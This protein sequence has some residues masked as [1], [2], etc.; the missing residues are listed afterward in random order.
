MR[1]S[2]LNFAGLTGPGMR[3]FTD[4]TIPELSNRCEGEARLSL[5]SAQRLG[6]SLMWEITEDRGWY[7][8][9]VETKQAADP[10]ISQ[11]SSQ[12]SR[13]IRDE[14]RQAEKSSSNR[15]NTLG[16]EP[17]CSASRGCWRSSARRG[18]RCGGGGAVAGVGGVGRRADCRRRVVRLGGHRRDSRAKPRKRGH[19]GAAEDRRNRE[20]RHSRVERR[21]PWEDL[22]RCLPNLDLTPASTTFSATSRHPKRV[23]RHGRSLVGKLDVKE[24]AKDKAAE[25]KERVVE[26]ADGGARRDGAEGQ[27]AVDSGARDRRTHGRSRRVAATPL[28]WPHPD[29]SPALD[30]GDASYCRPCLSAPHCSGADHRSVVPWLATLSI[31]KEPPTS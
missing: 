29:D 4:A 10:S 20:G 21:A 6:A 17:G 30:G 31:A 2:A 8:M 1:P 24:R 26:G 11:L 15:R 16:S 18:Y 5:V 19:P 28:S 22:I 27:G 14:L 23:G 13:L 9:S 3:E 7:P 12:V 25:T